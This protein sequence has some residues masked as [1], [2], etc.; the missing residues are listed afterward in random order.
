[1]GFNGGA[2]FVGQLAGQ[3]RGPVFAVLFGRL[4]RRGIVHVVQQAGQPP[5]LRILAKM[6]GQSLHNGFRSQGVLQQTALNAVLRQQCQ[7]LISGNHDISFCRGEK[8]KRRPSMT[9]IR[10]GQSDKEGKP[11][12]LR[13]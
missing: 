12:R 2:G 1:M 5:E 13:H 11:G 7:C 8:G 10:V 4:L 3:K 6:F 9:V